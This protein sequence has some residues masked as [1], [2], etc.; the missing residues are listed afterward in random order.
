MAVAAVS[1]AS[2]SGREELPLDAGSWEPVAPSPLAPRLGASAVWTGSRVIVWGGAE[3]T[4]LDDRNFGPRT[5]RDGASFDPAT[6]AWSPIADAPEGRWGHGAFWTGSRMLVLGGANGDVD[7]GSVSIY[8]PAR[9]SWSRAA[10]PPIGGRPTEPITLGNEASGPPPAGSLYQG[11]WTG[12]V[13]VVWGSRI[14]TLDPCVPKP[15]DPA[16]MI[17]SRSVTE[18]AAY[19][20]ANNRWAPIPPGPLSP[21]TSFLPVW[22]GDRM[23]IWGGYDGDAERFRDDG[24]QFDPATSTWAPLAD[25]PLRARGF[26]Y[27][28]VVSMGSKAL[29]IG[30][31]DRKGQRADGAIYEPTTDRWSRIAGTPAPW[32]FGGAMVWTGTRLLAVGG[33]DGERFLGGGHSFDPAT[34]R[35]SRVPPAPAPEGGAPAAAW[36]GEELFIF[37]GYAPGPPASGP[38]QAIG[39]GSR[40]RPGI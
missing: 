34:G 25:G 26:E 24:A 37:G 36:T 28:G 21:R 35:W 22:A 38:A 16:S 19:D 8:D 14:D 18:G 15:D 31:F 6:D 7:P 17:C 29:L 33:L 30:G 5:F 39:H 3:I 40:Y 27:G 10:T 4:G 2:C 12:T 20:P 1:L 11:V 13:L 32:H 9:N 23:V